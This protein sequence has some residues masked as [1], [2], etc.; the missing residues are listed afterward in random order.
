MSSSATEAQQAPPAGLEIVHGPSG[1]RFTPELTPITLFVGT[2]LADGLHCE[3]RPPADP[4]PVLL[5]PT[6]TYGHP[7]AVYAH[8]LQVEAALRRG[9]RFVCFTHN[10]EWIDA[11]LGFL[12]DKSMISCYRVV[13]IDG[14]LRHH[15]WVGEDLAF[16]RSMDDDPR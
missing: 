8:A 9:T 6:A 2:A 12:D 14:E 15:R 1:Q 5:V 11:L 7:L 13:F 16:M 10:L 3:Q 4:Q